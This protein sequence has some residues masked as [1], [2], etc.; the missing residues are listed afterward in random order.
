MALNDW[1]A[2]VRKHYGQTLDA[3][4]AE[5]YGG[6]W[7]A[8]HAAFVEAYDIGEIIPPARLDGGA[9]PLRATSH[10]SG[11]RGEQR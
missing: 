6:N 2:E 1:A 3:F 10:V 8:A 9:A 11:Y 4:V 5:N 7:D